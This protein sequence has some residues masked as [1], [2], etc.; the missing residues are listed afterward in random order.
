MYKK[1]YH[2]TEAEKEKI[3]QGK[4][5][6]KN[7]NFGKK[8]SAETRRKMSESRG[9]DKH[10]AYKRPK[11]QETIEKQR[12]SLKAFYNTPEGD[13]FKRLL[14]ELAIKNKPRLGTHTPFSEEAKEKMKI[15]R[16]EQ[17]QKP[18]IHI[19]SS[20]S[21]KKV[22]ANPEY[23]NR[24]SESHKLQWQDPKYSS[25]VV[26]N[27]AKAQNKHPNGK[28]TIVLKMFKEL[29]LVNWKFTDTGEYEYGNKRPDFMDITK[30][31]KIIEM[32]GD[33]WHVDKVRCYEETEEG[34]I[35][36]FAK[37]GFKTLIVW[38]SEIKKNPEAVKSKIAAF[39]NS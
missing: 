3:R 9:G 17:W 39:V 5:G 6:I 7:P 26:R 12:A 38:E 14:S 15:V 24:L 4:L 20:E 32:F 27:T 28:E 22:W 1:S 34:R 29:G 30:I 10:W 18:E 25:K 19:N 13:K 23:K 11:T 2:H 16:Q 37:Y 8:L 31:D 33:Y 35:A 36:H 21:H